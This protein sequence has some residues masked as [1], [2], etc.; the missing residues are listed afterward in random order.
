[1]SGQAFTDS[2]QCLS[3]IRNHSLSTALIYQ[4]PAKGVGVEQ[5]SV[6]TVIICYHD[7]VIVAAFAPAVAVELADLLNF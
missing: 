3:P 1:M 6:N 4:S 7:V 2:N 5:D